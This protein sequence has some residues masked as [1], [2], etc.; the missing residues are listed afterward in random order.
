[1]QLKNYVNSTW[2]FEQKYLENYEL[3]KEFIYKNPNIISK[4]NSN[5]NHHRKTIFPKFHWQ[6]R[7]KFYLCYL[8]RLNAKRTR[9]QLFPNHSST[10]INSSHLENCHRSC[11]IILWSVEDCK[12][13]G[14]TCS[15]NRN[16]VSRF[17][18]HSLSLAARACKHAI[19]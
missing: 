3:F 12:L 17:Y 10:S 19:E 6:F 7:Y 18:V 8:N 16:P 4:N 9:C 1:M 15:F 13:N 11:R 5:I 14:I 2:N